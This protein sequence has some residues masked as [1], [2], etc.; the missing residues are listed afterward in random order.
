MNTNK[1][2]RPRMGEKRRV[3]LSASV[4]PDTL[5]KLTKIAQQMPQGKRRLGAVFDQIVSAL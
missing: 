2:G 5:R 1:L 3:I 4:D